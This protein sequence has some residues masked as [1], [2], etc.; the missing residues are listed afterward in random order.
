MMSQ[1]LKMLQQFI[2]DHGTKVLGFS[3]VTLACVVSASGVIPDNH[4][5]YWML[6]SGLLTAWRGFYNSSQM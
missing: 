4:L 5:K 1:F 3:Q 6:A 2:K